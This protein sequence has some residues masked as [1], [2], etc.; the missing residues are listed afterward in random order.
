MV[1][2]HANFR[3]I[4]IDKDI[5]Y[6]Y[7]YIY[8]LRIYV[9]KKKLNYYQ[10]IIFLHERKILR[11]TK[12]NLPPDTQTYVYAL[13]GWSPTNKFVIVSKMEGH[14]VDSN[15]YFFLRESMFKQEFRD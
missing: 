3:K 5:Y 7:I 6:T 14:Y 1:W 8:I 13:N 12:K 9:S 4:S 15:V 11:K 2:C 10:G